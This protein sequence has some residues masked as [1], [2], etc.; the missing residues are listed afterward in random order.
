MPN[1]LDLRGWLA[2][3]A[4]ADHREMDPGEREGREPWS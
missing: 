4:A 3:E 2:A 1:Y